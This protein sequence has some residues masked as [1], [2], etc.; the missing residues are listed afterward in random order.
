MKGEL[1]QNLSQHLR[2]YEALKCSHKCIICVYVYPTRLS[3]CLSCE[4]LGDS[5]TAHIYAFFL[6]DF[7]RAHMYYFEFCHYIMEKN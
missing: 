3:C 1:I 6:Y 2:S 4:K 5:N 7:V